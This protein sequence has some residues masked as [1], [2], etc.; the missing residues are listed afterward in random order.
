[1][2]KTIDQGTAFIY[3]L[4]PRL[5]LSLSFLEQPGSFS[6]IRP[7]P[8]LFPVPGTWSPRHLQS[9][10]LDSQ[11]SAQRY[12]SKGCL[13]LMD[14]RWMRAL[15]AES[16]W[17]ELNPQN[18]RPHTCAHALAQTAPFSKIKGLLLGVLSGAQEMAQWLRVMATLLKDPGSISSTYTAAYNCYSSSMRSDSHPLTDIHAG[19][20][21]IYSK[22]I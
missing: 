22:Y 18:V 8:E 20:P 21:P 16:E 6:H 2:S 9:W 19:R 13:G 11:V 7:H 5:W 14:A 10:H 17:A 12:P 3:R 1:M 4:H 15:T